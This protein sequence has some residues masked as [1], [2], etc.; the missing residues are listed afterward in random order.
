[1]N[2]QLVS[3]GIVRSLATN[4]SWS[5]IVDHYG[6]VLRDMARG[7]GDYAT[8]HPL[9]MLVFAAGLVLLY[10]L[11][12]RRDPFFL[13]LWGIPLGYLGLLALGPTFSGF[14]Y[15]LVLV[16]CVAAGIALGVRAVAQR[17]GPALSVKLKSSLNA[18]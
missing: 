15:E 1:M 9:V 7:Y 3:G 16:P 14:R 10:V 18:S 2:D 12:D 5:F 13:L 17:A 6:G 4:A 8:A 11:G